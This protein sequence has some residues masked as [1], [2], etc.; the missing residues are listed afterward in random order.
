MSLMPGTGPAQTNDNRCNYVEIG[1][2]HLTQVHEYYCTNCGSW[3]RSHN[4]T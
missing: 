1:Q 3:H 2:E 4:T